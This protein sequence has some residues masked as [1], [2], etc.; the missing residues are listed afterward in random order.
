YCWGHNGYGQL[1]DGTT[2]NHTTPVQVATGQGLN[3]GT[4]THISAGGE[5]TC[6]LT[7]AVLSIGGDAYCWGR[8]LSGQLGDG[9]TTDRTTPVRVAAGQGL[10]PGAITHITTGGDHTCA[11]TT[12]AGTVADHAYCWGRGGGQLGDG[13]GNSH[14]TPVEVAPGQGLTPGTITSISAGGFHTCAVADSGDAYCWGYN[15]F[16]QLGN[17]STSNLGAYTPVRVLMP[18]S[19]SPGAGCENDGTRVD[20]VSW[21]NG[22][23]HFE[24]DVHQTD[25]AVVTCVRAERNGEAIFARDV[26]VPHRSTTRPRRPG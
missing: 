22:A 5:H 9:T 14:S 2:T 6:A 7:A 25:D 17:G 18:G 26:V 1:G 13:T 16:G 4:I 3:H 20:R 8:N 19:P 21:T 24:V 12:E 15:D 23:N 11:L 10:T